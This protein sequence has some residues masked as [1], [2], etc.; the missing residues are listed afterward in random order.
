VLDT[1]NQ[2]SAV[3]YQGWDGVNKERVR[4]TAKRDGATTKPLDGTP[5]K[6][7]AEQSFKGR[8]EVIGTRPVNSVQEGQTLAR[9]TNERITRNTLTGSGSTVGLPKLRAG[10]TVEIS[11]VGKNFSGRYFVTSTTHTL[12]DGGYTTQ[13]DCRRIGQ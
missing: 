7:Q 6:R 5:L 12:G 11:G 8:R 10:V 3:E 9:E 2:V 1:G 4:H 13:F